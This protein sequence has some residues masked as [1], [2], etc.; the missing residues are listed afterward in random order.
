MGKSKA[1]RPKSRKVNPTGIPSVKEL[2]ECEEILIPMNF[3]AGTL[4]SVIEKLQSR[5]GDEK[6]CAAVTIANMASNPSFISSLMES[7]AVRIAA[8]LLIDRNLSVRHTIAGCLRNVATCGGYSVCQ[9][10]VDQDILTSL[11]SLLQQYKEPWTPQKVTEG[12]IDSKTEI[13]LEACNLL[14]TLCES[15]DIAVSVFN[16][17]NLISILLPCL[18]IDVYNLQIALA[19]AQCLHTVA[20]DNQEVTAILSQPL[21][22]E[23]LRSLMTLTPTQP[24]HILLKTVAAGIILNVF[25]SDLN[26]TLNDAATSIIEVVDLTLNESITPTL[27]LLSQQI[28][29]HKAE[30]S[31]R[32][33]EEKDI[34]AKK[35]EIEKTVKILD[36]V[37]PAKQIALEILT[38]ICFGDDANDWDDMS[39]SDTCD[40]TE[41][42]IDENTVAPIKLGLRVPCE[43]HGIIVNGKLLEKVTNQIVIPSDEIVQS[44]S[45]SSDA[46]HIL[47]KLSTVRCR[48]LLC[49]NNM[50]QGLEMD[51]LGGPKHLFELWMNIANLLFKKNDISD[52]DQLE[53]ATS[54]MSAV[55]QKLAEADCSSLFSSFT[56]SDLELLTNI[57]HQCQ[58]SNI[59]VNIIRAMGT[60]GCLLGNLTLPLSS[61]LIAIIGTFLLEIS[62]KVSDIWLT[63]ESLD[64]IMDVFAEDH[65]DG[66]AQE[67]CLVDKLTHLLPLLKGKIKQQRKSLGEHLP[68]IMTAKTNLLRFIKYKE[69]SK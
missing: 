66:I 29:S 41:M 2:E 39:S 26:N 7:E 34:D 51:D 44:L 30:R 38:N 27:E 45:E 8:P 49:L 10:M 1:K 24:E 4:E 32:Y 47:S 48:A 17:K 37:L 65:L 53:A 55:L 60:I 67:I 54:S 35:N 28:A 52:T 36:N 13:F 22:L 25:S 23:Q 61:K 19:V 16:K 11:V 57:Y 59:K 18:N 12:K 50:V 9:A 43:I 15:C 5:E 31:N 42:D 40:E 69:R 58:D 64:V 3:E 6:E 33:H 20:E 68:V 63:A 14:W 21:V 46:K 56:E 62:A